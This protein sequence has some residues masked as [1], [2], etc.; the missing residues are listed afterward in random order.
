MNTR[1]KSQSKTCEGNDSGTKTHVS[2]GQQERSRVKGA[3]GPAEGTAK[4]TKGKCKRAVSTVKRPL[5]RA[6]AGNTGDLEV[7]APVTDTWQKPRPR[8][9]PTTSKAADDYDG[10]LQGWCNH[11]SNATAWP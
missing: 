6:R 4:K 5:K 3:K 10:N 2:N 9:P 7:Q 1:S 8:C 11:A